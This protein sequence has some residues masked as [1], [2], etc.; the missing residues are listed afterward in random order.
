MSRLGRKNEISPWFRGNAASLAI[1]LFFQLLLP[2]T[3]HGYAVLAHQALIDTTWESHLKP[4]LKSRY[5]AATEEQLSAAQAYAY[6]GS[7]IQDLGYYPH[8]S[9]F[10]S[11]LTHYVR[12]GD[13]VLALLRDA[14]NVYDYA[15]ALG[16]LSHYATDNQGH[17][18]ATNRAVPILYPKLKS[19]FGDFVTYEDDTLA[20]VKTE[21]G[22]DVL[23]VAH[24]QYAPESY[25]DFIG[26]E[27]SRSLLD[28]AF[29]QVYGVELMTVLDDEEKALNSYRHDVSNLIPQ[30]TRIAWSLKSKEIKA[31][32]PGATHRKF[33]Y[34]LSRAE[35]EKQWGKDY[36]RP[37]RKER[38]YAFLFKLLPKIGPLKVLQLKTPTPETEKMFEESFNVSVQEYQKLLG[39][40]RKGI[41]RLP[42]VNFDVGSETA[43]GKYRL[44]D[45]AH[46][47]LLHRLAG[48]KFGCVSPDLRQELLTFFGSADAPYDGKKDKKTW[49]RVQTELESL[50]E[51]EPGAGLAHPITSGLPVGVKPC[52]D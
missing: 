43:G 50:K 51:M 11:D 24:G 52:A 49:D 33:L 22:F 42:N 25:H 32:E 26:F 39:E 2:P 19:R 29:Q 45:D 30:A 1:L 18:L 6:G 35:Y 10:F 41:L 27:V 31:E 48:M 20:H 8:G 7:I 4:L 16:A 9:H 14:Q 44:N 38:F 47:Q 3:G 13:F 37:S 40:E 34:N 46:A 12:S 21:F 36:Q 15:F 28:Q 23:Q 5:P 17:R